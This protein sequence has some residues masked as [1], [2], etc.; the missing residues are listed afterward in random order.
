M[1]SINNIMDKYFGPLSRD[2][3]IY[4]YAMSIF[5]GV[6]FVFSLLSSIIFIFINYKKVTLMFIVNALMVLINTFL[7]YFVNRLLNTMCTKSI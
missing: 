3:C 4:F 1:S 7:A 2:Y 6:V 5:F